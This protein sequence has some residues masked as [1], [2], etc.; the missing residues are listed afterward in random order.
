VYPWCTIDQTKKP[1]NAMH[2]VRLWACA[3]RTQHRVIDNALV[4]PAARRRPFTA[5]TIVACMLSET[6]FMGRAHRLLQLS[7]SG[8][9]DLRCRLLDLPYP[10]QYDVGKGG[11]VCKTSQ[12]MFPGKLFAR[13]GMSSSR[14]RRWAPPVCILRGLI[15]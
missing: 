8:K 2:T 4:R 11:P 3:I 10:C 12:C 9:V 5:P 7:R 15:S 13:L 1:P 6:S 14:S